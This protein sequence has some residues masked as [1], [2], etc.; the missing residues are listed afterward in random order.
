[1]MAGHP[2]GVSLLSLRNVPFALQVGGNDSAYNRNKVAREYG[3]Q[4]AKLREADPKGYEHFVKIHEGKGH[5][6]DRE[7]RAAL[8]WLAKFIRN[9]VPDRVV[10]KQTGVPHARSY[11]L[12]VPE[13]AVKG[14]SLVIASRLGQ[15]IAI[16][17]SE[18]VGKL[19]LRLDDRM[20]DL[21]R[22]VK[23]TRAGK[24]LFAGT[25]PRTA[26]VMLRT[27]AGS[28]DPRLMFDAEVAIELPP[29]K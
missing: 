8:L 3:E 25:A 16:T 11:W 27:L 9:P 24:E 22:A 10:W 2:N 5:W 29:E 19:L 20:M 28:G 26:A 1:M 13:G 18:K 23:V 12:A 21:D 7:D 4:L 15:T 14:D 6:M 17:E